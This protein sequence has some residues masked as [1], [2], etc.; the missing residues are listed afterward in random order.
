M[1]ELSHGDGVLEEVWRQNTFPFVLR[2]SP[3]DPRPELRRRS[4]LISPRGTLRLNHFPLQF[5]VSIR[6]RRGD[7][8]ILC[9]HILSGSKPRSLPIATMFYEQ[10]TVGQV[11]K[12]PR[13]QAD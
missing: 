8:I 7:L 13:L 1:A 2:S 3:E 5:G 11:I 10:R 4:K 6:P 12:L 9:R